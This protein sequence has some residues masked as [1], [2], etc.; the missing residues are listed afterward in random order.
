[1]SSSAALMTVE[2]SREIAG[3]NP[4]ERYELHHGELV[5]MTVPKLDH[6]I[7]QK[8]IAALLEARTLAYGPVF[9]EFGFRATPE[10]DA[11]RAA[12]ALISHRRIQEARSKNEFFGAPDLVIE[13]LSPSNRAAEMDDKESLCLGNGCQSFWTLNPARRSAK[14]MLADG[15]VRRY[16]SGEA[17]DLAP[18]GSGSIA[19]DDLFATDPV[20]S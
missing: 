1:M 14:T 9:V 3:L 18:F 10:Y 2:E 5:R 7:Q 8:R 19:V 6:Q 13:I 11:R 12:V 20:L 17:I 4:G 15:H 16:H